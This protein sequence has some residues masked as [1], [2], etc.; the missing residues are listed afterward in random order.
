[1]SFQVV[2][3]SYLFL[4]RDAPDPQVLLQL[5]EGTGFRD[6][7]WAAAAAGHV[8]Q[9][10]S[11]PAAAVREAAEEL[12]VVVDPAD[13][14]PLVTLHRTQG[15]GRAVDERVDFFFACRRWS[16]VPRLMEPDKAADLR[17]CALDALPEP[18]VPHELRVLDGL[19]ADDLPAI[20]VDGFRDSVS[21]I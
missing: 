9:G 21:H 7:F 12:G 19:R 2:P 6:G 15:N 16:G 17:W 1:V 3:A 18:V 10:E 8:E 14:R 20:L 4:L 11:A 5:R 13:L